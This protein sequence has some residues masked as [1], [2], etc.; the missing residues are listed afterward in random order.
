MDKVSAV[1][2]VTVCAG[3][4][5]LKVAKLPRL[6]RR[7]HIENKKSFS[8]GSAVDAAPSGSNAFEPRDHLTIGDLDLD[9]PGILR[10]GN[11]SAKLRRRR[12]G[13]GEHAPAA[14]PQM[15]NVK[16]PAIVHLLHR[17]LECRLVI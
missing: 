3:A 4:A 2:K 14:M 7:A 10:P 9:R 15:S 16:I 13:D 8:E 11:V 1:V 6:G 17:Q 12:V 5:G